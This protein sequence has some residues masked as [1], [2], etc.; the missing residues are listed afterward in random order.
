MTFQI[1]VNVMIAFVWMFLSE[2]YTLITFLF[3]YIIGILLLTLLQRFFPDPFY[4]KPIYKFIILFIIFIQ[5][6]I[7][8]NIDIVKFVYRKKNDIESVI[9]VMP[10]LVNKDW[11][12]MLLCCLLTL[13]SFQMILELYE[14]GKIFFIYIMHIV[15]IKVTIIDIK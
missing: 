1:V 4:F 3:G 2:S 10:I 7:L 14:I 5:D 12:K 8:S 9:F 11:K 13:T 15:S 6:L